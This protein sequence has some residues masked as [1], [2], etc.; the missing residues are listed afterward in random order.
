MKKFIYILVLSGVIAFVVS[1]SKDYLEPKQYG[2]VSESDYYKTPG[3]GLKTVTSCYAAMLDN[4]AYNI[5]KCEL[6]NNITDDSDVGGSD[7]GD[8]PQV[9]DVATGRPVVTNSL[10]SEAW[11]N[12]FNGIGNCNSGLD[13]L[14]QPGLTLLNKDGSHVSDGEKSRYI[15]EMKFL[16]AWY[17]FDLVSIFGEVPLLTKTPGTLEKNTIKKSSI[18]DI[19]T[20]ILS[21]INDCINDENVPLNVSDAEYGRVS[22]Y[23]AYAFKAR[24]CL[25]FA[26]LIEQ[27]ILPGSAATEYQAAGD[28]AKVVVESGAFDLVPDYQELFRGNYLFGDHAAEIQKECLFTVVK[29]YSPNV[30]DATYAT[31]V[32]E[33]GRG[34]VVGGYGGGCVTQDLADAFDPKDPRKLFTIISNDDV[35]YSASTDDG[36]EKQ[37]YTGYYNFWLQHSRKLYIPEAYRGG[38]TVGDCRSNWIPYYIRYADVLLM[39]AEAL[40]KT[41]GSAQTACDLINTVRKRAYLT[42]SIND[43]EASFRLFD[44]D[45]AT[46]DES[47][48]NANLAV[49]TSDDLLAKIKYERRVELA[50]EGLRFNDLVRWG[51]YVKTMT[52]YNS[53]YPEMNKGGSVAANSWPFPIPK[54]EIDRS[55]NTL[56]QNDNY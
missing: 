8:R 10:L 56:V 22:R 44:A 4:W 14:T 1:C 49:Q 9:A 37:D 51:D 7:A 46:I 53:N 11:D 42:T 23:I 18:A 47:Y 34:S 39:Y 20:Q 36:F 21:D 41:G 31:P 26:G 28:A 3:A 13:G 48:F 50:C 25:F 52:N 29:T 38:Y 5:N 16:R 35:F 43:E 24:V 27:N 54:S 45:L 6:G 2:S 15:S 12:R 32:M 19:R 17:Y 33:M 40:V 55:N 30:M